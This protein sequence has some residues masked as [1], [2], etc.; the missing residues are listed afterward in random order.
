MAAWVHLAA[1]GALVAFWVICGGLLGAQVGVRA[2]WLRGRAKAV[3]MTYLE[4]LGAA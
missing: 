2:G 4:Y 1:L 3:A